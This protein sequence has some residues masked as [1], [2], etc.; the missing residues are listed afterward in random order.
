[1]KKGNNKDKTY[2][3]RSDMNQ[4]SYLTALWSAGGNMGSPLRNGF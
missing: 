2:E 3:K 1:M 4:V